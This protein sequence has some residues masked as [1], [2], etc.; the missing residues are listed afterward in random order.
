MAMREGYLVPLPVNDDFFALICGQQLS[1][2]SLPRPG[3]GIAGEFLGAYIFLYQI[4]NFK[5]KTKFANMFSKLLINFQNV[6]FIYVCVCF[7]LVCR[8][9]DFVDELDR[10]RASEPVGNIEARIKECALNKAFGQKFLSKDQASRTYLHQF[11][12]KIKM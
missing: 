3:S 8:C 5:S 7:Y 2:K 10:V 1:A 12:F 6:C 9:A 11:P 4:K